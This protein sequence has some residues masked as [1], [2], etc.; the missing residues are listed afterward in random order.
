MAP[1]IGLP[2]CSL[3][4]VPVIVPGRGVRETSL[5][6]VSPGVRVNVCVSVAKFG[7][8]IIIVTSPAGRLVS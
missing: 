8:D 6:T 2:I 3:V 4:I 5:D 1:S 7:V